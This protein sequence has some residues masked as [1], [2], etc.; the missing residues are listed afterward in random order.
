VTRRLAVTAFVVVVALPWAMASFS[1]TDAV[2]QGSGSGAA[3]QLVEQMRDASSQWSFGGT[4]DLTWRDGRREEKVRRATVDVTASYGTV[5]VAAGSHRVVDDVGTTYV[6]G[7]NGWTTVLMA[8]IS[9]ALPSADHAWG[10]SSRPGPTIAGRPTTVVVAARDGRRDAQRLYIDTE[11]DL[12]LGREVRDADGK[13]ARSLRFTSFTIE[14]GPVAP[15]P[16]AS[17]GGGGS[18]L[19][20]VPDGYRAP[21]STS[22]G[23][24]LIAKSKGADGGVQLSYSDGIFTVS[25]TERAGVLDWDALAA[26]GTSTTVA[27]H[28]AR[29]YSEAG[30]DVVVWQG[31]GVVFTCVSDAPMD[32]TATMIGGLSP[33][34]RSTI[35]QAVDYVL[36]PF[37]WH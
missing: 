32:V 37:G 30:G 20:G 31:E 28:T 7:D 24:V 10:L 8:P 17:T 19:R 23:Y 5:E 18:A 2:G 3:A 13:V 27:G 29:V 26:G 15:G 36:G 33:S 25:V 22:G 9:R 35:E 16:D 1:S 6:L 34:G 4:V 21:G 12:L 14:G 11:T